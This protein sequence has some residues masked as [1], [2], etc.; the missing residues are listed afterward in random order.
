MFKGV[1][2]NQ[3]FRGYIIDVHLTLPARHIKHLV[4]WLDQLFYIKN[5]I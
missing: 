4:D 2:Y 1:T 3:P 5:L